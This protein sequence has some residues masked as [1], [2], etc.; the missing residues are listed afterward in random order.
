[1]KSLAISITRERV[2]YQLDLLHNNNLT[3]KLVS[4]VKV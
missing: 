4:L 2:T 1:M 3:L